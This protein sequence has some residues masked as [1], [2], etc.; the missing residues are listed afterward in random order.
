MSTSTAIG[1]VSESLRNLLLGEMQLTPSVPV[2]IL[3]PDEGGGPRRINLFLYKIQENPHLRNLDWQASPSLPGELTP[4]PLSLNLYY[5][6]TPYA[7]NDSSLGN[8]TVHEILGEAMRVFHEHPVVPDAYLAGDLGDGREQLTVVHNGVNVEEVSQ[9]WSTFSQPF[10]L[11]VLYEVSVVQ[12]DQSADR[13]R[14]IPPRVRGIGVPGVGMARPPVV[15]RM[16][17]AS[18]PAGTTITFHGQHLDGWNGHVIVHRDRVVDG[19]PL[20]GDQFTA[21]IPGDL[22]PGMYPV[23]VDVAHLYRRTFFFEVTP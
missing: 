7:A 12:L 2:T 10:R 8:A 20:A 1:R 17:P 22:P 3:A 13:R 4:P 23:R 19:V 14:P 18:G 11:S 9:V 21:V 15:G 5:L 6:M 16:E